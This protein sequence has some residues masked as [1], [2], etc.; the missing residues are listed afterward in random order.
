MILGMGRRT[1]WELEEILSIQ[2]TSDL[3][4]SF[5]LSQAFIFTLFFEVEN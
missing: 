5:S 2:W 3:E 4:P 1:L